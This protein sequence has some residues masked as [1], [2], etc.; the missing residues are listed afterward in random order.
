LN[1][2]S[3]SQ[4]EKAVSFE[5]YYWRKTSVSDD[6]SGLKWLRWMGISS[7]L[8]EMFMYVTSRGCSFSFYDPPCNASQL[9]IVFIVISPYNKKIGNESDE[10]IHLEPS[11]QIHNSSL[12]LRNIQMELG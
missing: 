6:H 4:E 12:H 10:W 5:C 9:K 11:F 3:Q 8:P 1:Q 7:I 2:E